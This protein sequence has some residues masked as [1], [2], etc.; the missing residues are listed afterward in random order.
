M[1]EI[2]TLGGTEAGPSLGASEVASLQNSLRG[3]LILAGDP[4]HE[5]A[6]RVWNGNVDRR[7]GDDRALPIDNADVKSA[8]TFAGSNWLRYRCA[9]RRA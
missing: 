7:P 4:T 5:N 2:A 9:G 1:V 8:V 3:G 6:R